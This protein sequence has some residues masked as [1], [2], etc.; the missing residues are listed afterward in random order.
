MA[1]DRK[2]L[3]DFTNEGLYEITNLAIDSQAAVE[4][5]RRLLE[6]MEQDPS[7][8]F[9]GKAGEKELQ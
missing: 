5:L 7:R 2:G 1:E 9:F 6:Q 4:Q 8:F 3:R